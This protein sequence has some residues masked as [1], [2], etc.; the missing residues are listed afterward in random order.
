EQGEA[1]AALT[2]PALLG[3]IG[4]RA[5]A[6]SAAWVR[7]ARQQGDPTALVRALLS[8]VGNHLML[9][10]T[11][12][13]AEEADA[14]EALALATELRAP[15]LGEVAAA[16]QAAAEAQRLGRANG[17]VPARLAGHRALAQ[18][19][20]AA[21]RPAAAL[22]EL[23]P[24]LRLCQWLENPRERARTEHLAGTARLA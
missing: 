2:N 20:L 9:H 3:E 16:E 14:A 5:R 8:R 1:Y 4:P 12:G 13:A 17:H 24:A 11:A 21:G 10:A 22:A 18:L 23:A 15:A 7:L 6:Y 19:H